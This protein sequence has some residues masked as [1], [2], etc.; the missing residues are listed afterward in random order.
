MG[1]SFKRQ[2]KYDGSFSGVTII[3]SKTDDIAITEA[4]NSLELE[5][6]IGK[7]EE[8]R[9]AHKKQIGQMEQDIRNQKRARKAHKLAVSNA[10]NDIKVWKALQE[11]SNAETQVFAPSLKTNKRKRGP[12]F[13]H[14]SDDDYIDSND[15]DTDE[16][17][18]GTDSDDEVQ[19]QPERIKLSAA[20]MQDKLIC[21]KEAKRKARGEE[22]AI[23]AAIDRLKP[24][25]RPVMLE[26]D[27]IRSV[28]TGI[29]I[30]ERNKFS[31]S[32][33]QQDFAAGIKEIDQENSAEEDEESFDPEHE[34][35]DYR[36]VA[37]SLSVFCVSNRAYQKICGRMRMDNGVQGFVTDQETEIP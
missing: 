23:K 32:A 10:A 18:D 3:C 11:Q 24:Q 5:E 31:K 36:Q 26:E 1:E 22:L 33:I 14:H 13:E 29:C 30:V 2:L 8:Q 6:D 4:S 15:V 16:N 9:D 27:E 28:I 20:N 34:I 12:A 25:I 37:E 35:R 7:F 19:Y 17:T 21:L